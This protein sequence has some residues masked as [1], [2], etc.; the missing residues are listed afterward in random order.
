M[1][2]AGKGHSEERARSSTDGRGTAGAER[3]LDAGRG[4]LGGE[5][6]VTR[7]R[8]E[9]RGAPGPGLA[10]PG[11]GSSSSPQHGTR[12]RSVAK[13]GES[14]SV[15]LRRTTRRPPRRLEWDQDAA[16]SA[17]GLGFPRLWNLRPIPACGLKPRTP[18]HEASGPAPSGAF[19]TPSVSADMDGLHPLPKSRS[20][21]CRAAIR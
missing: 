7:A 5:A 16:D 2:S 17:A 4:H 10:P 14:G 18:A 1:V 8:P 15:R 11:P 21:E 12:P 3:R 19:V 20:T 13:G 6:D 9:S